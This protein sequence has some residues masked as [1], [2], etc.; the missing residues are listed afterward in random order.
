MGSTLGQGIE[1]QAD[2][3]SFLLWQFG[4]AKLRE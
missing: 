3:N 1:Q 4:V 2:V